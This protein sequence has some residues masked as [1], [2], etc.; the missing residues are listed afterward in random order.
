MQTYWFSPAA[1]CELNDSDE[2]LHTQPALNAAEQVHKTY[3]EN[4]PEKNPKNLNTGKRV[5]FFRI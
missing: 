2:N 4:N 5:H 1:R 3:K